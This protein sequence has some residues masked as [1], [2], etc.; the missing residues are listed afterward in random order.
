M[1]PNIHTYNTEYAVVYT[2]NQNTFNC[3][4]CICA[5][6]PFNPFC[7]YDKSPRV[8]GPRDGVE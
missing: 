5:L 7:T 6:A 2:G 1:Y 8:E 3:V 4:V